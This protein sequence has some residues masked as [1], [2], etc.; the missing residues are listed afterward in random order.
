MAADGRHGRWTDREERAYHRGMADLLKERG[1][2][3]LAASHHVAAY[4]CSE[5]CPCVGCVSTRADSLESRARRE[6]NRA[7][8]PVTH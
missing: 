5:G 6:R 8:A 4:D 2:H 1:F 7:V 3:E